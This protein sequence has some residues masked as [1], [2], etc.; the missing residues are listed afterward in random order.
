MP[1][2]TSEPPP[3][4]GEGTVLTALGVQAA[5]TIVHKIRAMGVLMGAPLLDGGEL[6]RHPGDRSKR[7]G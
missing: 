7:R 1:V 5:A 2:G 6:Y 4:S 3:A